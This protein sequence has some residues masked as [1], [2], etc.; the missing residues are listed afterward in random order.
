RALVRILGKK[1]EPGRPLLY[2]TTREFLQFFNLRDLRELP[3]LREFHELSDEHRA[4][5]EAL[6]R[7]APPG[8]VEPG[9]PASLGGAG[10][11]AAAP[12][13]SEPVE[14]PLQRV[15]LSEEPFEED[16][17]HIDKLIEEAGSRA[18]AAAQALGTA[19]PETPEGKAPEGGGAGEERAP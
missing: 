13:P 10:A 18:R 1:E 14:P 19:L 17:G 16:L 9:P 2:G 4:Q 15:E 6:E 5:V 8:S 11:P 3:T 12:V 7:A